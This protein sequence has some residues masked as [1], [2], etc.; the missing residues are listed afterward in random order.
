MK[1]TTNACTCVRGT[2]VAARDLKPGDRVSERDG[3]LLT[4][5]SVTVDGAHVIVQFER[6]GVSGA[7]CTRVRG[8]AIVSIH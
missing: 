8:N 7:P 4:V 6:Y 2:R 1:R 3:A 5:A